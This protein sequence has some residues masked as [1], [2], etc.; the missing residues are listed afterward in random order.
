M[1]DEFC[2]SGTPTPRRRKFCDYYSTW[3]LT[4]DHDAL[5]RVFITTSSKS[6]EIM[7]VLILHAKPVILISQRVAKKQV[8]PCTLVSPSL[9]SE[10]CPP[11]TAAHHFVVM[12]HHGGLRS[13]WSAIRSRRPQGVRVSQRYAHVR[14]QVVAKR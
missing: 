2:A 5:E 6:C 3:I 8:W 11:F 4:G 1:G 9:G 12:H 13:T 7:L 14:V 10:H